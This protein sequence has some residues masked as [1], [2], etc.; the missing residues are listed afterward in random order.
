MGRQATGFG[1]WLVL[2]VMGA[3]GAAAHDFPGCREAEPLLGAAVRLHLRHVA[4]SLVPG[5]L[6]ARVLS[7]PADNGGQAGKSSFPRW[8][9]SSASGL[10][11]GRALRPRSVRRNRAC[12]AGLACMRAARTTAWGSRAS[13]PRPPSRR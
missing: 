2:K 13:P 10:C 9:G 3:I 5:V 11:A 7:R 4:A 12:L 6:V 1:A 8:L